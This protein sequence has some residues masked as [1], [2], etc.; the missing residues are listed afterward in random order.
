MGDGRGQRGGGRDDEGRE[1]ERLMWRWFGAFSM[2]VFEQFR[3][4]LSLQALGR[5]EEG[6]GVAMM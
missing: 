6:I 2:R 1:R 4:D 3:V 5:V